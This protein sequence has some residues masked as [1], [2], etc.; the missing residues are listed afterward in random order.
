MSNRLNPDVQ[1]TTKNR[2]LKVAGVL[3]SQRGYFGVAMSQIAQE[4][5]I[6]KA[7][8][9]YHFESKEEIYLTIL[10]NSFSSLLSAL[11]TAF[12]SAK[13]P[14]AKLFNV[15]EAY[16]SFTLERP[17]VALLSSAEVEEEGPLA[18][19]SHQA[20]SQLTQFLKGVVKTLGKGSQLSEE[21]II[22]LGSFLLDIV[23]WPFLA[24]SKTPRRLTRDIISLFFPQAALDKPAPG[25]D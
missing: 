11:E 4:V 1:P 20:R 12:V 21:K 25:E 3:F 6:T 19:F 17:E 16:L 5:G 14:F 7:A 18:A 8:L 9:Y 13:T 10:R 22:L 15:I 24:A 23:R 2:I